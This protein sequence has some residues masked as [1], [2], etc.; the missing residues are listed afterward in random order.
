MS[1]ERNWNRGTPSREERVHMT[2]VIMEDKHVS[3]E[4]LI[5][6]IMWRKRKLFAN[7]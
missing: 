3:L 4:F 2:Q 5:K 6:K 7:S 1:L